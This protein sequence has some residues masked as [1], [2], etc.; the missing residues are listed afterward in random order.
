MCGYATI[1]LMLLTCMA[2]N[3]IQ[4][5]LV[6]EALQAMLQAVAGVDEDVASLYC[7][8]VTN[9]SRNQAL[10]DGLNCSAKTKQELQRE[11]CLL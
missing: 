8:I 10:M 7:N 3:F 4:L 6:P 1:K 2:E 5:V 9:K 11:E